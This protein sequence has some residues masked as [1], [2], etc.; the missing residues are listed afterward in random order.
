MLGWILTISIDKVMGH[1]HHAVNTV[2]FKSHDISAGFLRLKDIKLKTQRKCHGQNAINQA[3]VSPRGIF[4][5]QSGLF[6]WVFS[7]FSVTFPLGFKHFV[8]HS[9]K[10]SRNV[11]FSIWRHRDEVPI[12]FL[13]FNINIIFCDNWEIWPGPNF[14][15]ANCDLSCS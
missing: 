5:T 2:Y 7:I 12:V 8:F 1:W 9:Q 3:D 10:P 4:E 15:A 13:F 14:P 6:R 11:T